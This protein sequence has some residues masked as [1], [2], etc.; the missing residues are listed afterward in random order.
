MITEYELYSDERYQEVRGERHLLLGGIVCTDGGRK[1]IQNALTQVRNQFSLAHEMRWAKVSNAYLNAYKAWVNVFFAD[2]FAR[3]TLLSVN[4]SGNEWARFRPRQERRTARDDKLAS[5]FY[6]F[7]LVTFGPLRDT[8]RWWVYPDAG[9]FS[10]DGVLNRVEFL[11]NRTYKRAF[12]AKTSRIIRFA[13][14]KD[15]RSSDIIQLSDVLLG[16]TSCTELRTIPTSPGRRSLVEYCSSERG[17]TPRTQR[18][19]DKLVYKSWA[20]PRQ[21]CYS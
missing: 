3:F 15:S 4:L 2:P 7:L 8:K 13:R 10:N 18:G 1:R 14:A 19:L 6:Q 5:L 16:A 11:L 20:S 21:F 17:A 9:F 12:G